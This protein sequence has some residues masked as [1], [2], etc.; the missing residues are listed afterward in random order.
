MAAMSLLVSAMPSKGPPQHSKGSPFTDSRTSDQE[1]VIV[2]TKAMW[3][4]K[5]LGESP[6]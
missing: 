5:S 4:V 3:P 1:T 6:P 2:P